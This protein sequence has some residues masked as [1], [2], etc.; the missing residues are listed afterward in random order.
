MAKE[1]FDPVEHAREVRDSLPIGQ[2]RAAISNLIAEVIA[3]RAERDEARTEAEYS[4]IGCDQWKAKWRDAI[5]HADKLVAE[6]AELR[7]ELER[8]ERRCGALFEAT[9]ENG[10]GW[11]RAQAWAA[12]FAAE[13]DFYLADYDENARW[14]H[15]RTAK[16]EDLAAKSAAIE[17]YWRSEAERE[18]YAMLGAKESEM[19]MSEALDHAEALAKWFAA[20]Q[21]YWREMFMEANARHE[22][23]DEVRD[24]LKEQVAEA[25]AHAAWYAAEAK[26]WEWSEFCN[27]R[28]ARHLDEDYGQIIGRVLEWADDYAEAFDRPEVPALLRQIICTEG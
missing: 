10:E 24:Y 17:A 6:D 1:P 12:W 13:R 26:W 5:N 21:Y 7:A 2:P 16:A 4:D 23:C 11:G 25:Q 8:L 22:T 19:H 28:D 18:Y 14:H 9:E 27:R 3:A 15:R 20:E